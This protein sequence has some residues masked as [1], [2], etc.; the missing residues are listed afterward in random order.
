MNLETNLLNFSP[1]FPKFEDRVL[2]FLLPMTS[3]STLGKMLLCVE[4][5]SG[6]VALAQNL[7]CLDAETEVQ[8][9][10]CQFQWGH[11]GTHLIHWST[12][13]CISMFGFRWASSPLKALGT[14]LGHGPT[15]PRPP[16]SQRPSLVPRGLIAHKWDVTPGVLASDPV[17]S[18]LLFFSRCQCL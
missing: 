12:H 8:G 11:L 6:N 16:P 14:A 2:F 17:V 7:P 3:I 13:L 18:S 9:A 1:E 5:A 10:Q 4:R 15:K